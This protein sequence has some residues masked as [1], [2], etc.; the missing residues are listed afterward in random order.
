M[1]AI[2]KDI[3]SGKFA[4]TFRSEC[5]RGKPKMTKLRK[6]EAQLPLEKTGRKLR[7]MMKWID[8]KEITAAANS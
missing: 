5:K 2:L 4:R 1:K 6:S 3:Q 8:A 7:K